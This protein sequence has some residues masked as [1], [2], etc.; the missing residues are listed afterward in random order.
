MKFWG[1]L[2][3]DFNDGSYW[4][5]SKYSTTYLWAIQMTSRIAKTFL[6]LPIIAQCQ[7]SY[8]CVSCGDQKCHHTLHSQ[9]I[10]NFPILPI[11][12]R[13]SSGFYNYKFYYWSIY[14]NCLKIAAITLEYWKYQKCHKITKKSPKLL[15]IIIL[16][17]LSHTAENWMIYVVK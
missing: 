12:G 15:E 9:T 3:H 10:Q 13:K 2:P 6:Q 8:C 11:Q 17:P 14:G 5:C 1:L 4:P 16:S 7:I